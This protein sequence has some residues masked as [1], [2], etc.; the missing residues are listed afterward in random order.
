MTETVNFE[1]LLS[2]IKELYIIIRIKI[3][4]RE[5]QDFLGVLLLTPKLSEFEILNDAT[6]FQNRFFI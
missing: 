4:I 1:N 5:I 6:F 2:T 3:F